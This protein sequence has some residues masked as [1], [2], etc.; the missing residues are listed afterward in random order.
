MV[1][2]V[3]AEIYQHVKLISNYHNINLNNMNYN[4]GTLKYWK[5]VL[6]ILKSYIVELSY[7]KRRVLNVV[8]WDVEII[9][10]RMIR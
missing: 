4:K 2:T 9:I 10:N 5:R 7:T 6:F 8:P 3:K 1:I